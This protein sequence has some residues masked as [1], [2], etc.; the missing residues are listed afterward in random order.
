MLWHFCGF[1]MFDSGNINKINLLNWYMYNSKHKKSFL[2]PHITFSP[3][4]CLKK[5]NLQI[6]INITNSKSFLSHFMIHNMFFLRWIMLHKWLNFCRFA[7]RCWGGRLGSALTVAKGITYCDIKY[8]CVGSF[9]IK[10]NFY[11][12]CFFQ[13]KVFQCSTQLHGT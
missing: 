3:T 13:N 5:C 8:L 12:Y 6:L 10:H 1:W 11:I 2:L 4:L 9:F 7:C